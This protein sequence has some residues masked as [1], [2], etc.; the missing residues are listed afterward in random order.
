MSQINVVDFR[1]LMDQFREQRQVVQ[2]LE[3]QFDEAEIPGQAAMALRME[4]RAK[5]IPA[6]ALALDTATRILEA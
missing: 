6:Y 3:Q 4:L 2:T 1:R 5:L